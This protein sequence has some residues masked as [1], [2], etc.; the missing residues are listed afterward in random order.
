MLAKN[1]SKKRTAVVA[2]ACAAALLL[3]GTFAW[4]LATD[5]TILNKFNKNDSGDYNVDLEENFDPNNPWVNKDVYVT[6]TGENPVIVRVRLEEFYDLTYRNGTEYDVKEGYTNGDENTSA[7]FKPQTT[8]ADD[9]ADQSST[10]LNDSVSLLFGTNGDGSVVTMAEF[11]AMNDTEKS[12]VKWVIDTD[13]W[14][15]YTRALLA[16]ES[17]EYLLDKADFN[18]EIFESIYGSPYDL[19]YYIN[20]RLQAISADLEDF[21]SHLDDNQWTNCAYLDTDGNDVIDNAGRVICNDERADNFEITANS[22]ITDSARDLVLGI[23]NTYSNKY[24]NADGTI[25]VKT[26]NLDELKS[27]I[28][29]PDVHS[30]LLTNNIEVTAEDN[31]DTFKV[32]SSAGNKLINFGGY[33]ISRTD[34][35]TGPNYP[36]FLFDKN[37]TGATLKLEDGK[38]D[39]D[40]MVVYTNADNKT[41]AVEC[42]NMQITSKSGILNVSN[43]KINDSKIKTYASNIVVNKNANVLIDNSQIISQNN[44]AFAPMNREAG[45]DIKIVV[46]N[47]SLLEGHRINKTAN[48]ATGKAFE[49]GKNFDVEISDTNII[50]SIST[51]NNLV[52]VNPYEPK[53]LEITRCNITA[54]KY[55]INCSVEAPIIIK[56]TNIN[57]AADTE[58]RAAGL[59]IRS[60]DITLDNV[61]VNIDKAKGLDTVLADSDLDV[62]YKENRLETLDGGGFL[63]YKAENYEA[64]QIVLNCYNSLNLKINGGSFTT[65]VDGARSVYV[66]E[67]S[68]DNHKLN[69]KDSYVYENSITVTGSPTFSPNFNFKDSYLNTIVTK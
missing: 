23:V 19:N 41:D 27:A 9:S 5:Q 68:Y 21:G 7:I 13:G 52:P 45:E 10:K 26:G 62:L 61:N 63:E 18:R 37:S 17:T 48:Y 31:F 47:N 66:C 44:M 40:N 30:I 34:G 67:D 55:A 33:K 32:G 58:Q 8:V 51:F 57:V 65:N 1:K 59:L 3:S 4:N 64:L 43:I 2:A 36:L 38:I 29:N 24:A 54:E 16:G 28:S 12:L 20:V 46:R 53:K 35:K 60:G 42:I 69:Y 50:G 6:N 22:T 15:Y 14:C 56:D 39:S 49:L 11:N 25:G